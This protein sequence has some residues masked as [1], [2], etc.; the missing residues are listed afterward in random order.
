MQKLLIKKC[1]AFI[2]ILLVIT[3]NNQE[4]NAQKIDEVAALYS[5][6]QVISNIEYKKA[7]SVRLLLDVYVQTK[8][9]G[10]PPWVEYSANRKP[11]L[12]FLHGG[13]WT[14]GDK[15]SRSLFLM[16]YI[17]KGW[18]IVTA[19]YRHLNE[20]GLIGIISDA[21]SA[22][23]WVYENAEKYK[24]DT[25]KIIVSGESAGGH[26]AL[27]AGLIT[28]DSAFQTGGI[29]TGR[30]LK[31]AGIINWFGVADLAKAS[32][33]WDAGYYK[34]VVGDS[35]HADRIFR[36]SSPVNY[37]TSASPPVISIHGDQDK[38]APYDQAPLLHNKLKQAGVKNYLF[39][40]KGKKHGNFDPAD[41]TTIY[42]EIWK[43]LKEINVE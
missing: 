9:L 23:N 3:C 41:M 1:K 8:R 25:S 42:K 22:L 14:S 38:A 19:N 43:F 20:T 34:Q 4:I 13:G 21:R 24:F 10:E 28:N 35:S 18:C 27:M 2:I 33:S 11:T 39:T 6:T 30:N 32:K 26:L 31:V 7:D 15:I 36:L 40:V 17:N 37:I 12:L 29:A 16:P 5:N